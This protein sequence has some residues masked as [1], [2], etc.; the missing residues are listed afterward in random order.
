MHRQPLAR[1]LALSFV[2][3]RWFRVQILNRRFRSTSHSLFITHHLDQHECMFTTFS[4]RLK[5]YDKA[6]DDIIVGGF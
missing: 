4:T 2:L 6:G 1:M 3:F 5:T